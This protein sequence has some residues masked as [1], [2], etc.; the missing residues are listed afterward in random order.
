M[1]RVTNFLSRANALLNTDANFRPIPIASFSCGWTSTNSASTIVSNPV[2]VNTRYSIQYAPSSAG[3]VVIELVDVPLVFTDNERFLSFNAKI[4]GV[5]S[6]TTSTSLFIDGDDSEIEPNSQTHGAGFFSSVHSNVVLVED[7]LDSRTATI[8]ISVTAHSGNTLF[9]TNPHLIDNDAFF[10]NFFVNSAVE[11]L[12]DFYFEIDSAQNNPTF[13]FFKLL[14]ALTTVAG[15][16]NREYGAIFGF[17][18][19]ELRSQDA[20]TEYWGTSALVSPSS[21]RDEY[22]PWLSQFAGNSIH[23]NFLLSDNTLYFNN[24]QLERDFIEWQMQTSFFGRGAGTRRA[25]M[26]AGRQVLIRTKNNEPSSR[27]IALTQKFGGDPFAIK[28]QTLTNETIDAEDGESSELVLKV[29]NLAKPIG[30]SVTHVAVDEFFFTLD[31]L[32]LGVIGEQ[33]VE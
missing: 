32:T 1:A 18:S 24:T 15:D 10:D 12:P 25:M 8:R 33:R 23:R 21:V 4:R 6:F 27:S 16:T 29:V 20:K 22:I 2:A 17:E 7:I 26:D 19:E 5:S 11:Y 9:F 30:Y 3:E 13:P 31:D 28:I 14:D